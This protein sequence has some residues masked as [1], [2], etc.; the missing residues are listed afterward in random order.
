MKFATARALSLALL[1]APGMLAQ[2]LFNLLQRT[3]EP[4]ALD[5]YLNDV[6]TRNME[7]VERS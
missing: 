6:F 5:E 7:T 3:S 2:Y 1:L 4:Y